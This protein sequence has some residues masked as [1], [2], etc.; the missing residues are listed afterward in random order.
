METKEENKKDKQG[1]WEY[2]AESDEYFWTGEQ[3]P[4]LGDPFCNTPL[5]EEDKH[6]GG[7]KR[8]FEWFVKERKE[9]LKVKRKQKERERKEAM[10]TPIDPLPE[11]ELC[12]YEKV[13]E[14]NIKEREK[15]MIENGFF[16]DLMSL[17]K[18]IGFQECK[19][20][21]K[22]EKKKGAKRQ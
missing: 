8:Q 21:K 17:K 11:H 14:N 22:I 13:R 9:L 6:E 19:N 7:R 15:A 1:H 5:T 20:E 10:A 2:R 18:E 16:E 12:E 3:D 4:D